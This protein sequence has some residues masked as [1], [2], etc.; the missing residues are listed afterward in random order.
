MLLINVI[1]DLEGI[2]GRGD[3]ERRK[4]ITTISFDERKSLISSFVRSF[5]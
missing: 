5:K 3:I 4:L 2:I 1:A